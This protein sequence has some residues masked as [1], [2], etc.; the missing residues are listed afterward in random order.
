VPLKEI[1]IATP[2]FNEAKN[3]KLLISAVAKACKQDGVSCSLFIIDDMSPDHTADIAEQMAKKHQSPTF[4]VMILRRQGKRGFGNAYVHGF[5]TILKKGG[6]DY[7]IQMD[8]DLSHNPK[9]LKDFMKQAKAGHDFVVASRYISG[10]ATP[11]WGLYRKLLSR[12]GNLYTRLILGS[13][14]TDYT[15]GFNMY[16]T[17]LLKAIDISTL[18]AGGYGFLIELKYRALKQAKSPAQ[19][20]IV[21]HDRQHGKSKLPKSTLVKNLLL[22]PRIKLQ[23]LKSSN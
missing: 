5:E 9:Y 13:V 12:G 22:V 1:A 15:G 6:F 17:S 21:F 8:A 19:I 2:T 14:V 3:I 10:G 23:K 7:V 16:S 18:S 20:P 11:D 4:K